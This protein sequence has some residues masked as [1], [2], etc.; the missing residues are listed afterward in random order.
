MRRG[1]VMKGRESAFGVRGHIQVGTAG[2]K[3]WHDI[4]LMVFPRAPLVGEWLG[5]ETAGLPPRSPLKPLSPCG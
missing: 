2:G 3:L 1:L 5:P 4:G